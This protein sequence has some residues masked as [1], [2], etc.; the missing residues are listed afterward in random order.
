MNLEWLAKRL[1]QAGLL[2][3]VVFFTLILSF[4]TAMPAHSAAS[5]ISTAI[6][7]STP[8]TAPLHASTNNPNYF[9]DGSGKTGYLTG[10]HTWNDF[11]DW[12]TDDSPQPFDFAAWAEQFPWSG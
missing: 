6:S 7:K 3:R 1:T 11:Q 5:L 10:S 12:G 2:L 9:T 4:A 8:I